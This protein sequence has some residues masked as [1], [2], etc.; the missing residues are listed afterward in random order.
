M[1]KNQLLLLFIYGLKL[2]QGMDERKAIDY[3]SSIINADHRTLSALYNTWKQERIIS[4]PD[5]SKMG[6]GNPSHPFHLQE[7][8]IEIEQQIHSKIEEYNKLKGFR[9]TLD[10]QSF[11]KS[12]FNIEISRNGLSRRLHALGYKWGRS[13]TMG[14]MTLAAR[15]ARGVTY[16]KELSLAIGEENSNNSVIIYTDESYINVKHKIQYTWY[17]IYSPITNEVG[18]PTGKGEREMII[19]SISKH[20]LLGGDCCFFWF[21]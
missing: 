20:G 10:I 19:H 14:G 21:Y 9:N 3:I 11:L 8:G 15:I 1:E 5:T 2:N 16:M 12:N 7:W 6:N 18:G 4:S 13:R 17:S